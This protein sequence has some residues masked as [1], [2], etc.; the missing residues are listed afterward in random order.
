MSDKSR[1]GGIYAFG[2][3]EGMTTNLNLLVI[4]LFLRFYTPSYTSKFYD[5]LN[6]FSPAFAS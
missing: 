4:L 1:L 3:R 6:I 5:C 2:G